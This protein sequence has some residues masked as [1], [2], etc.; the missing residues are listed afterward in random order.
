MDE[1]EAEGLIALRE[2]VNRGAPPE[3]LLVSWSP[4]LSLNPKD[5]TF[6]HSN[7]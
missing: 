2:G 5:L 4:L 3:A 6:G 1:R 7:V